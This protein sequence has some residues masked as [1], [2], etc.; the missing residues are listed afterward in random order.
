M[1]AL[2]TR[3]RMIAGALA[4]C[5]PGRRAE[6]GDAPVIAAASSL[7]FALEELAQAFAR[8]TGMRVRLSFGSSGNITRQVR[9][10]APFEMV[11]SAD[12]A[13]IAGLH[14][15]GFTRDA[16]HVYAVGRLA[17]VAP[18]GS[19]LVPDPRMAGLAGLLDRGGLARFA[20]ANPEH[21]PFGM[22]AREALIT[23]GIWT[24]IQPYLVLGENA[25]Q[26]AQ[27][28][29]SGNTEGGLIPLSLVHVPGV[30][31]RGTHAAVPAGWHQPLRQR[32]ALIAGAGAVARAFYAHLRSSR[33]REIL[34]RHGFDQPG[35]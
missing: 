20:I 17:L 6:A 9:E 10:G 35:G 13:F 24:A 32:M 5:L 15:D 26:A 29:L 11:M 23:R 30:A 28:A 1:A 31:R 22:R 34:A 4:L 3:R 14:R 21:A 12:E 19:P 27:F 7:R 33:G 16:G 2:P 18:P 25:G 8:E